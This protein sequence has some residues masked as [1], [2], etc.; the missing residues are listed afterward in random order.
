MKENVG[1]NDTTSRWVSLN[2]NII[3][4]FTVQTGNLQDNLLEFK[5]MNDAKSTQNITLHD[6]IE[7][8]GE[9]EGESLMGYPIGEGSQISYHRT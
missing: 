1:L 4:R 8:T 6:I 9:E 5:I 3:A 7:G 2:K